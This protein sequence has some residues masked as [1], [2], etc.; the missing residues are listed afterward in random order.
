[1]NPFFRRIEGEGI[2][3]EKTRIDMYKF[4]TW[5]FNYNKANNG[6]RFTPK[7]ATKEMI[8]NF[9]VSINK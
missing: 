3:Y 5:L 8:D 7:T 4:S 1:M 9:L 2:F 6:V